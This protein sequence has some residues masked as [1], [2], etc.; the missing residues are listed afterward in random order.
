MCT[1]FLLTLFAGSW[2]NNAETTSVQINTY[3]RQ[4][5][6]KDYVPLLVSLWRVAPGGY[7]PGVRGVGMRTASTGVG[8]RAD[9][10]R[11]VARRSAH[12][13][14]RR[15]GCLSLRASKFTVR[16]DRSYHPPADESVFACQSGG[17]AGT[18]REFAVVGRSVAPVAATSR[19]RTEGSPACQ[20]S[21]LHR[22]SLARLA[23][24]CRNRRGPGAFVEVGSA[25]TLAKLSCLIARATRR[26]HQ[27]RTGE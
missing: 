9:R 13:S 15:A 12:R 2:H 4:P 1:L 21:R 16:F 11:S 6:R 7:R 14:P 3:P 23:R 27:C 18:G 19:I 8:Y 17:L 10:N 5:R 20:S 22:W 24:R 25:A 26:E